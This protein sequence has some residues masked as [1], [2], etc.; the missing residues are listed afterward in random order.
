[1]TDLEKLRVL[2]PH[3]IA[4]NEEH[5]LEF[6]DWAGKASLAG[7]EEATQLIHRAAAEMQQA[8]DALKLAL[9]RVGGPVAVEPPSPTP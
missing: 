8:N 4:H 1:M 5:A 7:H 3:W 2:L 9:D 6:L